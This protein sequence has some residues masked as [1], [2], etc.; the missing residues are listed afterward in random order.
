[1][2]QI[3]KN[4]RDND[5]LRHS[6]NRLAQQ[7]FGLTFEQWYQY[8]YW[9]ENYIPYSIAELSEGELL[10]HQVYGPAEV[11]LEQ[12]IEAFGGGVRRA[13]LGFTPEAS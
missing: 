9:R 11:S 13:V 10:L 7:T 2:E 6:F 8:G 5:G 1:M 12:V 4:Y 3:I